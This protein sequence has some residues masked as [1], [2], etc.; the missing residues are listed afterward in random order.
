MFRA[1]RVTTGNSG[2][3]AT[4]F[5]WSAAAVPDAWATGYDE[6][7]WLQG[8]MLEFHLG[9]PGRLGLPLPLKSKICLLERSLPLD[10][11][12]KGSM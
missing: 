11:A 10:K 5:E 4:L 7:G 2:H 9:T 3:N 6:C 8:P 12:L 1:P